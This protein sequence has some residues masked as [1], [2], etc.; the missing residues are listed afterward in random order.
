MTLATSLINPRIDANGRGPSVRTSETVLG[1]II[2]DGMLKK[3]RAFS[4]TP[5]IMAVQNGGGIRSDMP[6]GDITVGQIITVLH[7]H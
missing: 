3:A 6:A 2:T 4:S 7:L 5:V 1:N